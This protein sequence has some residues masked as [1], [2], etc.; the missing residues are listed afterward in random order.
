ME[1]LEVSTVLW[2]FV[3]TKTKPISSPYEEKT[4]KQNNKTNLTKNKQ[5]KTT[6]IRE[7]ILTEFVCI[8][9]KHIEIHR[10]TGEPNKHGVGLHWAYRQVR[11]GEQKNK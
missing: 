6:N 11:E 4:N 8:Y 9:K 3:E 2:M 7:L 5:T 10:I 1:T